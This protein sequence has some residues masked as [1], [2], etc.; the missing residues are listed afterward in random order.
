MWFIQ[1][2][3]YTQSWSEVK[4]CDEILYIIKSDPVLSNPPSSQILIR[5]LLLILKNKIIVVP[6]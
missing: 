2:Y 6:L 1:L 4:L 5:V 3:M